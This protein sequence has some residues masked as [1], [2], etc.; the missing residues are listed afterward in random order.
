MHGDADGQAPPAN[1]AE[2]G[3]RRLARGV[4]A[5][6]V[7]ILVVSGLFVVVAAMLGGNVSSR[8][9]Q[10]GF[11]ANSEQSVQAANVLAS[12]FH[13]G[14]DNIVLLVHVQRGTVDSPAVAD[15][16]RALTARLAAQRYMANV[17][18]YWSL[19]SLPVLKTHDG[20]SA[21]VV[22]RILGNQ[23]QI[24]TREPAIA[25]AVDPTS[26]PITVQVGGFATA[27]H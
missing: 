10:G 22:G 1:L 5:H 27:F 9:S 4:L 7:A 12:R 26:G 11:D 16:G 14:A 8:L 19:N 17:Q 24:T 23:D 20:T 18:S 25:A 2:R 13:D 6:R 15:A 3:L 21:L